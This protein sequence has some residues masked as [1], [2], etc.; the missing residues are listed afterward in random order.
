MEDRP[1]WETNLR[2]SEPVDRVGRYLESQLPSVQNSLLHGILGILQVGFRLL[3]RLQE[4]LENLRKDPLPQGGLD[5]NV[6]ARSPLFCFQVS[7][8]K[9]VLKMFFCV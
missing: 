2:S 8:K 6:P 5:E 1:R 7:K 9:D 4:L 3:A